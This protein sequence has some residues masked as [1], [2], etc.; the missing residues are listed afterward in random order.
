[1]FH[2]CDVLST[3]VKEGYSL[4]DWGQPGTSQ[5]GMRTI[6]IIEGDL[7]QPMIDS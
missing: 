4:C 2:I 5:P 7:K 6:R 3:G 1:M